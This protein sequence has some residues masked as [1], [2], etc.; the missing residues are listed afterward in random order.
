V[1]ESNFYIVLI[2][3]AL[4]KISSYTQN[5]KKHFLESTLVQD[6]VVRNFVRI[7]DA[8]SKV[9]DDVKQQYADL[10]WQELAAMRRVLLY[11]DMQAVWNT[12]EF[13]V[14]KLKTAIDRVAL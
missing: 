3:E 13:E 4:L 5:G 1:K 2:R 7:S 8:A 14:E 11:P 9:S 6:A 10:P 12:V